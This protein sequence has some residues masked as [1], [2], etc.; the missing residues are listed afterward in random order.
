MERA[1]DAV[2]ENAAL[3]DALLLR[4]VGA[5]PVDEATRRTR[6]RDAH[7]HDGE[8]RERDRDDPRKGLG[9]IDDMQL[10]CVLPPGWS[11]GGRHP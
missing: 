3:T 5:R 11:P 7:R 9:P 4:D 1:H 10:H 6:W 8:R 2:E